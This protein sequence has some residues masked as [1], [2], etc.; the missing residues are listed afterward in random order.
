MPDEITE[1]SKPNLSPGEIIRI[2]AW[3]SRI[4]RYLSNTAICW[5]FGAA[6]TGALSRILPHGSDNPADIMLTLIFISAAISTTA[7]ALRLAI[8]RCPVC[9]RFLNEWRSDNVHCPQCHA[10]VKLPK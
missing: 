1:S 6:L 10:Q 8:H 4:C 5:I 9:D 2:A 7:L 3:R